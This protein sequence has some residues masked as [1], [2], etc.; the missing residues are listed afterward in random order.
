MA[1]VARHVPGPVFC[2]MVGAPGEE[3]D[4][5]YQLAANLQPAFS[6][7]PE[8]VEA[9]MAAITEMGTFIEELIGAKRRDP[10]DDLMSILLAAAD[11]GELR[12]DDVRSVSMELLGASTENT[13][14]SA[15]LAID[16][17][18][19]HPAEWRRLVADRSLVA[20][21]VEECARYSPRVPCAHE[22]TPSG[23]RVLDLELPSDADV[24]Y[25]LIG[26]CFDPEVYPDPHHF[27]IGRVHAKPQLNF[28][29]GSHFCP[30]AALA[31]MEVQVLLDVLAERWET[32]EP[33]GDARM[34]RGDTS[35]SVERLALAVTPR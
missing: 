8:Q 19:A 12:P 18:A 5:L 14:N 10:D 22:W 1:E 3:G 23:T 17:L 20:T 25:W 7:D 2:W 29:A 6:G 35:V 27:D 32:V 4:R 11:A 31:R 24:F 34:R 21:A 15:G 33:A 30:G 16:V 26:G 28:G 9:V 13:A